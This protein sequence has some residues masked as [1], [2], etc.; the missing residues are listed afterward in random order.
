[1]KLEVAYRDERN[2]IQTIECTNV[3]EGEHGLRLTQNAGKQTIGYIPYDRLERV[4][5]KEQ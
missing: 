5:P 4:V 2:N 3:G 1:M